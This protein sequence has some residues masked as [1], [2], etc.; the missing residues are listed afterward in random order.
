MTNQEAR[1]WLRDNG[2]DVA[3]RG[4]ISCANLTAWRRNVELPRREAQLAEQ[5]LDLLGRPLG[6][7]ASEPVRP[8][9]TLPGGE[10]MNV[11]ETT[12]KLRGWFEYGA[13]MNAVAAGLAELYEAK[14]WETFGHATWKDYTTHEFPIKPKW[15]R[16]DRI[17]LITALAKHGLS[18]REVA[19][20][21]GV[22]QS[23]VSRDLEAADKQRKGPR[24]PVKVAISSIEKA[25]SATNATASAIRKIHTEDEM[26]FIREE[27]K[28][29]QSAY[30]QVLDAVEQ[31]DQEHGDA[32]ASLVEAEIVVLDAPLGATP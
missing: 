1:S 9:G 7:I 2:Y 13:D 23:T 24:E 15:A 4:P 26:W 31:F 30:F 6:E 29:L 28:R 12:E 22:D 14:A 16:P 5:G 19:N 18:Q 10:T 3:D 25:T 32:S 21:L 11:K 17:K 8:A 27:L 20:A